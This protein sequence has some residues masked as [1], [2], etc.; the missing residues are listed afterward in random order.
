MTDVPSLTGLFLVFDALER[1]G[2]PYLLGGSFASSI[3]GEARATRDADLL[4]DMPTA[5]ADA[6]TE[7]LGSSFY[8][9][10]EMMRTSIAHGIS[11]NVIHLP[12]GFKVDFY[13]AASRDFEDSQLRRRRAE[14]IGDRLVPVAS[15]EDILLAKLRWYR[16]GGEVSD[17]QW[18][19][20][21]GIVEQQQDRL[22]V[23]YLR[24][25]ARLL[26][27]ADLLERSLRRAERTG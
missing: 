3:H 1:L 9:D 10:A 6:L 21:Q 16:E 5:T 7:A 13:S 25:W 19:D 23:D 26:G 18:R 4:I 20:V 22:D 24:S 17:R 8:A 2:I 14:R 15:P 27:V 12:T 11:F